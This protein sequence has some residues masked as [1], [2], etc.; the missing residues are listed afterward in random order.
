MRKQ[1]GYTVN[2]IRIILFILFGWVLN[3]VAIA[4]AS[5]DDLTTILILRFVGIFIFPMGAVL[6]YLP[7]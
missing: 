4:G 1:K 6:G 7:I 3:I 5:L 2:E